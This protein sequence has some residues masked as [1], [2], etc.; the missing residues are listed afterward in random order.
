MEDGRTEGRL[1]EPEARAP[2]RT[3]GR[4]PAESPDNQ[5]SMHEASDPSD[6]EAGGN[7]DQEELS[8]D[9]HF[10][11]FQEDAMSSVLP[12]LPHKQG[13]HVF[14]ATTNNPRDPIARRL[15]MGYEFIRPDEIPGWGGIP[16][17]NGPFGNVIQV[18]EMVAMQIPLRLY[19]RMMREV[20]HTRP[21]GEEE[22]IR[23]NLNAIRENAERQGSR[24][25]EGDGMP[26][27]V[28]R[29]PTPRDAQY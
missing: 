19:N 11:L 16:A 14:W 15:R 28:Q 7:V 10:A 18:N 2:R 21:L 25:A 26:L 8:E 23:A 6:D 27:L 3:G 13:Y 24:V 12:D 29:A 1:T 5:A 4:R 20:H 17:T 9:E 22:K